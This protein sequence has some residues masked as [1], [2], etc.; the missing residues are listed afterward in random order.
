VRSAA[1]FAEGFLAAST[2]KLTLAAARRRRWFVSAALKLC[3]L[4]KS[5]KAGTFG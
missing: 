3:C 2:R 1:A 5:D 4:V